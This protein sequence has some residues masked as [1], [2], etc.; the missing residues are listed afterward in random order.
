MLLLEMVS[1]GICVQRAGVVQAD[2]LA[3]SVQIPS[4]WLN[5]L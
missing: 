4:F 5:A 1:A 2:A 3:L